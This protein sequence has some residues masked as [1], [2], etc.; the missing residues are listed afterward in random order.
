MGLRVKSVIGQLRS[1]VRELTSRTFLTLRRYAQK[2]CF[3]SFGTIGEA[4]IFAAGFPRVESIIIAL[5]SGI[6]SGNKAKDMG[7]A[8]AAS[9]TDKGKP[10]PIFRMPGFSRYRG[11]ILCAILYYF[12]AKLGFLL[13][14]QPH[15]VSTFWPTNAILI[16]MML[17]LPGEQWWLLL[18]AAFPAH[19]IRPDRPHGISVLQAD[20]G[21][22]G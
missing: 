7:E 15:P 19:P 12:G 17:L 8:E 2:A 18:V 11:V 21:V 10:L 4:S 22:R 16:A 6:W 14:Y 5:A 13:T 1:G 3:N 20:R 9:R